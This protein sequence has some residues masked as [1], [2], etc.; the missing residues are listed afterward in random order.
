MSGTLET[1]IPESSRGARLDQALAALFPEFSRARLQQWIH[2]G[3]VAVDGRRLR[4]RD[5]V[6]GGERVSLA[7]PAAAPI[8]HAAQPIALEVVH[9]DE[10]VIVIAKPAGLV[11]HPGAGNPDRTLL[12]ALLHHAP[13]L[14]GVPRA[15]L[16]HRLDKDTSG[17]LLVARSLPAHTALTRALAARQIL[18]EYQA[19]CVG[20]VIGGGTVD[21]PLGRHPVDRIKRAVRADGRPAR[22]HY[23]VLERF[24]AHSHLRVQLDTGRTHQIRVHLAHIGHPL[25]G[26]PVYA[27]RRAPLRDSPALNA[28]L[29]AFRRQALHAARLAFPHPTRGEPV[30]FS[31]APPGDFAALLT[32]LR[33]DSAARRA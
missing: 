5:L 10:A 30:E 25:L 29:A 24:R 3:R 21:A 2:A 23:R 1:V 28:A 33:A 9:E 14:A 12:N 13:E 4:P 31:V 32:E 18:R 17:V 22:T 7:V 20:R 16:I 27:R 19:L 11:V 6:A 15:G 8:A 26:D